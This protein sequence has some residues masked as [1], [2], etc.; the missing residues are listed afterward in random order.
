MLWVHENLN[1]QLTKWVNTTF[2]N[3]QLAR[4]EQCSRCSTDS[5]FGTQVSFKPRT[6][7]VQPVIRQSRAPLLANLKLDKTVKARSKITWQF[8]KLIGQGLKRL[9]TLWN[10]TYNFLFWFRWFQQHKQ[11]SFA[12]GIWPWLN[13]LPTIS[14]KSKAPGNIADQKCGQVTTV[15]L[16]Q[17]P[18]K[19][20]AG[21][22][23][24]KNEGSG[25]LSSGFWM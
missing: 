3:L 18:G 20:S 24:L 4:E 14:P 5:H 15:S 23:G 19:K 8:S 9:E 13:V 6:H 16:L 21:W 17:W 7:L 1:L 25:K 2:Q 10:F 11:L 22:F 12:I